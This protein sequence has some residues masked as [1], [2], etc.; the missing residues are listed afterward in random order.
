MPRYN[1]IFAKR[2]LTALLIVEWKLFAP[3]EHKLACLAEELALHALIEC[4]DSLRKERG[5]KV[6]F[7]SLEEVAF[8]DRDFEILFNPAEDGLDE[9][10]VGARLGMTGM[11][12]QEW[13]KPFSEDAAY[14][15][16]PFAEDRK[17]RRHRGQ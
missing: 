3:G 15:V 16:H 11:K 4:A 14:R 2:F 12:F 17:K 13:F 10:E 8:E 9:T 1:A 5:L 7:T 6:D